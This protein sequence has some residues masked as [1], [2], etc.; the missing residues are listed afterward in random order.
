MND[1]QYIKTLEGEC[2][3]L[4]DANDLLNLRIVGL[5]SILSM[6]KMLDADT[7]SKPR[8]PLNRV[9]RES[10]SGPYCDQCGSSFKMKYLFIRTEHCIQSDCENYYG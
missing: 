8:G 7:E 9:L 5:E 2:E 1:S 6:H 3:S 4:L 10:D